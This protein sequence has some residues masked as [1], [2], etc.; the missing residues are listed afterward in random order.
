[1]YCS[2][3]LGFLSLKFHLKPFETILYEELFLNDG[4]YN[5]I[6]LYGNID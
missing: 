4:S 6:Q 5:Y 2:L 1:M 3:K